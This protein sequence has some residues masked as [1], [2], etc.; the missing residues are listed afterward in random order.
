[1][2][3]LAILH[4]IP[5]RLRVR[6]PSGARTEGVAEAVARLPGVADTR[7]SPRTRSLLA[8]YRAGDVDVDDLLESIAA[9]AHVDLAPKAPSP[10]AET[11]GGAPTAGAGAVIEIFG[12]LNRR[13]SRAT[14]GSLSLGLLVPLALTLWAVRDITRGP[15]RSLPWSTALWYAHG[16]FRD[17]N[18]TPSD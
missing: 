1:M 17:Y 13:I 7:W 11:N 18:L 5:G 4:D 10:S 12:S 2:P 15:I 3:Q 6:L 16:L 9:Q 14:G 8:V